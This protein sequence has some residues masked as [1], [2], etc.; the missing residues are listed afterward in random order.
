MKLFLVLFALAFFRSEFAHLAS[1]VGSRQRSLLDGSV[2]FISAAVS[3]GVDPA[4]VIRAIDQVVAELPSTLSSR[5][6]A[7]ARQLWHHQAHL[8]AE[9]TWWRAR[10]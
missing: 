1:G 10:T 3:P 8:S 2:F 5:E 4:D 7:R 9:T 6:I